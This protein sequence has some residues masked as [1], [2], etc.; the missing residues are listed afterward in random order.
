MDS[1][2][3]LNLLLGPRQILLSKPIQR[4]LILPTNKMPAGS[5]LNHVNHLNIET[6][7]HFPMFF[8]CPS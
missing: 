8:L 1:A 3:L 7:P 4:P 6:F 2:R 5:L